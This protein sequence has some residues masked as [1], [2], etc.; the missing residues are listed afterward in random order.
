MSYQPIIPPDVLEA[1]KRRIE[2]RAARRCAPYDRP[3]ALFTRP[4]HDWLERL[5]WVAFAI[6]TAISVATIAEGSVRHYHGTVA[7]WAW[8][9]APGPDVV[10]YEL[11]ASINGSPF[12]LCVRQPCNAAQVEVR[13]GGFVVLRVRAAD[14]EGNLGPLSNESDRVYYYNPLPEPPRALQLGAGLIALVAMGFGPRGSF[15]TRV[16]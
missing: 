10:G 1:A 12:V 6:V 8:T 5:G 15:R 11:E 13:E 16:L 7:T 14:A 4:S 3:R 2:I 9:P